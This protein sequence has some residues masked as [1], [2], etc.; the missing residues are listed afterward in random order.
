MR[1]PWMV[2]PGN[3]SCWPLTGQP[4]K[5]FS[6]LSLSLSYLIFTNFILTLISFERT[7]S[8]LHLGRLEEGDGGV[9]RCQV[10]YSQVSMM[11]YYL[12]KLIIV[13]SQ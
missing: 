4:N 1:M 7:G 5:L 8:A 10:D 12:A 11:T 13:R 3:P 6:L 2:I 9:Y